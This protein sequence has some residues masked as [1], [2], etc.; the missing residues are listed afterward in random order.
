[1]KKF[2]KS[3]IKYLVKNDIEKHEIDIY[4]KIC[5]KHPEWDKLTSL[6]KKKIRW[7]DRYIMTMF[8]NLY[9]YSEYF[10]SDA[11]YKNEILPRLNFMNYDKQGLYHNGGGYFEDKNYMDFFLSDFMKMPNI[12]IRCINGNF[13]T[14]DYKLIDRKKVYELLDKY[15]ELVIKC[16]VGSYQGKGVK[17]INKNNYKNIEEFGKNF[18]IQEVLKQHELLGVYNNS[19]INV[20]RI[21]TLNL[22]GHVEVL[23]GTFR[24]GAPGAFRDLQ[25]N[26]G[27][28]SRMV[29]LDDKGFLKKYALDYNEKI[30]YGDIFGQEIKGQIPF[31]EEMKGVVTKFHSKFSKYGIIGWDLTVDESGQIIC[32]EYNVTC[33]AVIAAQILNGPF[34][35][36]KTSSGRTLLEEI[37]MI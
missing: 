29:G 34:F 14:N 9:G 10:V 6:E 32:I 8:K 28:N 31:Y 37:Y 36:K 21:T 15:E 33:P 23:S 12:V 35:G 7:Q 16:S 27:V 13:Y 11:V 26:N 3:K 17:K 19:S 30:I 5:K 25:S 22:K 2:L 20:V 24:I 1:M 4:K 18:V